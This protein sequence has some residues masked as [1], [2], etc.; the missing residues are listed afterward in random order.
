M[1]KYRV[2]RVSV[3]EPY[4]SSMSA[5]K[6]CEVEFDSMEEALNVIELMRTRFPKAE[7][8]PSGNLG[9]EIEYIKKKTFKGIDFNIV[10][11]GS[12]FWMVLEV[13]EGLPRP[14]R[15]N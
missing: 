3:M 7:V 15:I 6:T 12:V 11:K 2:S 5:F 13:G 14:I 10:R 1:K 8:M 4:G 9:R